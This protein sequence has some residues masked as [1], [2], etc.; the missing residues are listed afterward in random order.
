VSVCGDGI[1]QNG[2]GMGGIMRNEA[3]LGIVQFCAA[4]EEWGEFAKRTQF[5]PGGVVLAWSR[6]LGEAVRIF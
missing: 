6:G 3:N 1:L 4:L 5:G 2:L